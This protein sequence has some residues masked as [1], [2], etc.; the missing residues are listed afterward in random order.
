MPDLIANGLTL[1]YQWQGREDGPTLVFVNGLLTDL[2]SWNGHLP[3]FTE[4]FHCLTY[5]CRGQGGSDKPDDGPYTPALHAADLAGLLDELNLKQAAL[6]GVSSGGCVALQY[7]VDHPDRVN[8]LVLANVYGRAD[9]VMNVKLNSWDAAMTAGGGPLRFD[10]SSPWIW[11]A[12]YLNA[13]FAALKPWRERGTTLPAHAVHHL[14]RGSME[15]DVLEQAANVTCPTLLMTGDEDVLTPVSYA[16]DL[17]RRIAGSRIAMLE[18]AGH[19]M[20]LERTTRFCQ[21]ASEFLNAVPLE[22]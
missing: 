22:G 9:T 18:Q 12:S 6:L 20:F 8:A 17:Q 1:H 14:I 19:C 15:F 2:S 13:N 5:D 10:V 21:V 4:R 7:A 16:H 3:H 11:G